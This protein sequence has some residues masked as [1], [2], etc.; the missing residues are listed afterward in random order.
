MEVEN[1]N[2]GLPLYIPVDHAS[3]RTREVLVKRTVA[4]DGNL[5]KAQQR[6]ESYKF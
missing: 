6:K 4:S 5:H 2:N 3:V 1:K